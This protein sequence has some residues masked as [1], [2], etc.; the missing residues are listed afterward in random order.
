VKTIFIVAVLVLMAFGFARWLGMA[1][2]RTVDPAL[3]MGIM[4]LTA[5][6][7]LAVAL[8]ED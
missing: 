1:L 6:V 4:A 3:I 8:E 5:V 7:E 2:G